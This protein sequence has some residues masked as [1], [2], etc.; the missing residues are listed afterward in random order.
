M[1]SARRGIEKG[2]E[3]T[4]GAFRAERPEPPAVPQRL[5]T[6]FVAELPTACASVALPLTTTEPEPVTFDALAPKVTLLTVAA[7]AAL[8]TWLLVRF[9]L[10]AFAVPGSTL[11]AIELLAVLP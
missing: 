7:T 5:V 4:L 6:R 8:L 9:V 2:S 3:E 11:S 1:R 10:A